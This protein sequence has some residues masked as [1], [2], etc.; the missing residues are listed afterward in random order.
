MTYYGQFAAD[1][2]H[3]YGI[4]TWPNGRKYGGW[5]WKGELHGY[6]IYTNQRSEAKYGLWEQGKRLKWFDSQSVALINK[7]N[8]NVC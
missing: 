5:W 3:G 4:Y 6:G 8:Y 2:K 1:K 7:N